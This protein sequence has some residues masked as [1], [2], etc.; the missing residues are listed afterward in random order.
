M[1]NPVVGTGS[2]IYRDCRF[3]ERAARARGRDSTDSEL[4]SGWAPCWSWEPWE[5]WELPFRR[6]S[7][8]WADQGY[9]G[10]LRQWSKEQIGITLHIVHLWWRRLKR[11]LPELLD[12]L[13]YQPGFNVILRRWVVEP[14]IS[15]L[16]RARRL[17]KE[18]LPASSETL[19][20]ITC[21]RLLLVRLA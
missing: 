13:G 21:T 14:T 7:A 15:R 3:E 1:S 12:Q 19:I 17:S 4:L 5:P 2:S 8:S 20:Y 10:A 6:C 9:A 18:R 11:Y 16:G